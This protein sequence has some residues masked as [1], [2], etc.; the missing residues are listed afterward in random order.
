MRGA[1]ATTWLESLRL[2]SRLV[3]ADGAVARVADWPAAA[4]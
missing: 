2:P 1:E 4:A 3:T